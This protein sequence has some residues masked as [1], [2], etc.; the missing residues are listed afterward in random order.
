MRGAV[1]DPPTAPLSF[2]TF[3]LPRT[4]SIMSTSPTPSIRIGDLDLELKNWLDTLRFYREEI[5]VF[6]HHMEA[7]AQ[8]AHPQEELARLEH[9]Q[10]QYIRQREVI[11]EL[12]HD[13]KQHENRLE[14]E[15]RDQPIET[16]HSCSTGHAALRDRMLTF[17]KLYKEVKEEFVGWLSRHS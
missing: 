15:P 11:D 8:R 7:L 13:L 12:R 2:S 1:G 6:E 3:N 16:D 5:M 14:E 10:N 4:A 17:E 9:F